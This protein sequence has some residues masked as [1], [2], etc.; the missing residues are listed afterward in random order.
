MRK[1]IMKRILLLVGFV[2]ISGC[3]DP[4]DIVLGN[5]PIKQLSEQGEQ[6]KKL[7]EHDRKL[8]AAYFM[9]NAMGNALG[10][11]QKSFAGMT[12]GEVLKE[13]EVW[14]LKMQAQADQ[15]KKN[16]AEAEALKISMIAE[17]KAIADKI[18]A[19]VLVAVV[20]KDVLPQDYDIS[21]Y[22]DL[23]TIS[24]AIENKAAKNIVQLKG[25]IIFTDATGDE[26]GSLPV[27]FNE[28][29]VSGKVL[30]TTTGSGWKINKFHRGDIEKIAE[31]DFNLIK[32]NFI[33]EAIAFEDGEVI[34]APELK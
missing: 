15:D 12:V 30:K 7:S 9:A 20:G 29:V 17:R 26:I 22:D 3:S 2:V 23:L 31:A 6:V 11:G 14:K 10:N 21:R 28:K 13:A 32:T 34:K 5:D 8:L 25:Q 27:D 24:Y 1:Q 33:P 19:S 18:T 16:Q 4:R